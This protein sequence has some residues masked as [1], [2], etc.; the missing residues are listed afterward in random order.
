[1]GDVNAQLTTQSQTARHDS[2]IVEWPRISVCVPILKNYELHSHRASH[3]GEISKGIRG[4][5]NSSTSL[6]LAVAVAIKFG[7][8]IEASFIGEEQID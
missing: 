3:D 2:Q 5:T 6:R 4:V 8:S 1:M 7:G